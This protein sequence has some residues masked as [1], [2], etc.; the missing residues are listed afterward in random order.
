MTLV[1]DAAT[2]AAIVNNQFVKCVA[3]GMQYAITVEQISVVNAL[4]ISMNVKARR[5]V[6]QANAVRKPTVQVA[7]MG[8]ILMWSV[9]LNV[10]T[11]IALT[12]YMLHALEA[13]KIIAR[14]V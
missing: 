1:R 7:L 9:V 12:D 13:G 5:S 2:I 4:M 6:V 14:F 3:S 8:R 10:R 11:C